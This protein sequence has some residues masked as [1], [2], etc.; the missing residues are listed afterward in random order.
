MT[1][2]EYQLQHIPCQNLPLP[3]YQAYAVTIG[4]MVYVSGGSSRNGDVVEHIYRFDIE[5]NQWD[6]LPPSE[7]HHCV[8]VV[9]EGKLSLIGGRRPSN[10]AP[11][12]K[13]NTYDESSNQWVNIYPDM[14]TP[15]Y[16]PAIVTSDSHVIV[17]GGKTKRRGY[18]KLTG[19]IE[20]MNVKE[21]Q[22]VT[23]ATRLPKR[24]YNMSV[25]ISNDFVWIIDNKTVF[26]IPMADL[27]CLINERHSWKQQ[28][29]VG[30]CYKT[31]V[32]GY[33]NPP[34]IF[35]GDNQ[36]RTVSAVV[37]YDPETESW[38]EVAT[39]S[40]PRAYCTVVI[41]PKERG[42]LVIGGCTETR[43]P[44]HCNS[45]CLNTTE[46]YYISDGVC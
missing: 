6:T 28:N 32:I 21:K 15:R 25:T 11:V 20:I 19:S 23:L 9:L 46:I 26:I 2:G 18:R 31:A 39:L 44:R 30:V 37:A 1:S 34:V 22:W 29:N 10:K 24:M 40:S 14:N 4:M 36:N 27:I 3:V 12:S 17:L 35:G 45:S 33:S 5:K 13:V 38:R 16:R 42:I 8:L 43:K 7:Y 41:L